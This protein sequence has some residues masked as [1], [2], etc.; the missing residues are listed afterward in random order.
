MIKGNFLKVGVGLAHLCTSITGYLSIGSYHLLRM[1]YLKPEYR[2][3]DSKQLIFITKDFGLENRKIP[4]DFSSLV[5]SM[6]GR[7]SVGF[8][9]SISLIELSFHCCRWRSCLMVVRNYIRGVIYI[10]IRCGMKR[11]E[12]LCLHQ[13]WVV[14][15]GY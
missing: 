9:N 1:S 15:G 6:E 14:G 4:R 2:L 11:N 5:G 13:Y 3:E 8:D 10:W 12:D 7:G